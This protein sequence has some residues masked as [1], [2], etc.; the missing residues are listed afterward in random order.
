MNRPTLSPLAAFALLL[1]AALGPAA[2]TK[3]KIDPGTEVCFEAD[4]LPLLQSNCTQIG[5]HNS[6]DRAEDVDLTRYETILDVVEPGS[7][8]QSELYRVLV[9]P[10]GRMPQSPSSPLSDDQITVI[11][12]WIEQGALETTDC[13]PACDT[14]A[15]SYSGAVRPLLERYC[16]GCHGGSA[17]QGDLGLTAYDE[18]KATVNAGLLIGSIRHATGY[19]P[20]PKNGSKLS[21]C[22]IATIQR[23]I[24][25][26]APNN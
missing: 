4:V 26:G 22:A 11:A 21:D 23:W 7:Y 12:R 9:Q 20:M 13:A 3:E 19:A 24:D 17:P 1:V 15:S 2:C 18:V 8:R 5:C 25:A 10:A 14:T 6:V 16:T